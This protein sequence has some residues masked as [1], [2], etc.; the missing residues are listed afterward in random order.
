MSA[1]TLWIRALALVVLAGV[2]AAP[3][4]P[5]A[6]SA[7]SAAQA[8]A[9]TEVP[10]LR[11]ASV[12]SAPSAAPALRR[13]QAASAPSA[14]TPESLGISSARLE[15]LH[16]GMQAFVD[17][18]EAAGIVT[19]V[20]REGTVV[21]VHA[22]GFQDVEARTPMRTDTLFRIASMT[23]PVTSVAVMMLYEEGKLL[24]TDPLSKFIPAFKSQR[25]L[26]TGPDAP[27]EPSPARR[28]I[29]VRDLLAHRSGL[30]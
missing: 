2:A 3:S 29:N 17:R 6:A 16:A 23:K 14:A 1:L 12:A 9:G 18:R 30:T 25:V 24:L 22:S 19:L 13:A 21:D 15:R 5:S 8:A 7:S 26:A 11:T 4:A 28:G 20:A 10:A 27:A